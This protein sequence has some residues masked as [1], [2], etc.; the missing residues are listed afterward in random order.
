MTP[1]FESTMV[2]IYDM[3]MVVPPWVG[4]VSLVDIPIDKY[5]AHIYH[6][7]IWVNYNIS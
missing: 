4:Y 3:A 6:I 5:L 7:Y 1:D 2:G